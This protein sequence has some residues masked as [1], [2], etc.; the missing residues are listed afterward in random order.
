M[1]ILTEELTRKHGLFHLL[2]TLVILLNLNLML[3]TMPLIMD[4]WQGLNNSPTTPLVECPIFG[5]WNTRWIHRHIWSV[6][7][8][9]VNFTPQFLNLVKHVWTFLWNFTDSKKKKNFL[10]LQWLLNY[11]QL[12]FLTCKT[13]VRLVLPPAGENW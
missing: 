11:S 13:Y 8:F 12:W 3:S 6:N 9:S 7:P 1:R 2:N 5:Q 10:W 4:S